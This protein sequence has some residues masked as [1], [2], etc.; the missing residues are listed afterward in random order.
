MGKGVFVGGRRKKSS[1]EKS[2]FGGKKNF[3]VL[4]RIK[5]YNTTHFFK[6]Q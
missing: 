1:E 4:W 5:Q 6:T 2:C 3:G